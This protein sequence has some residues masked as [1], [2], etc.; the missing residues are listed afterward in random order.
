MTS[1]AA[2][3]AETLARHIR[4]AML[5]LLAGQPMGNASD[6]V[7][8][9]ALNAMSYQVSRETVRAHIFWLGTVGLVQVL[10]L[11][12]TTGL[13][14]ATLTEK[15]SDVAKGLSAIVGVEPAALRG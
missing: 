4:L 5:Q 9:E 6:V 15:G 3:A 13:V 14:G 7:L 10:D 1:L 12:S 8:Y 11:R 2:A